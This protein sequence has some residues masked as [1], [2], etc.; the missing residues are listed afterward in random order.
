V[1]RILSAG[2]AQAVV[3][4]IV[5]AYTSATGNAVQADFSAV[6]AMK[7]RVLAG[8]PVDVVILTRALIDELA[9]SGHVAAGSRR[10]L[11]AVA[12]G[13]AVRAGTPLPDVSDVRKLRGNLLAATKVVCPD[14]ATAT[15][16]KAVMQMLDKLGIVAAVQ[17]RM[18]Y[19]P[20]GYA[21][22]KWLAESRGLL[23]MGIT[24]V[25]EILPN[26]GVRYVGPLP[27]ELRIATV[28]SA[29][30][31]SRAL[32]GVGAAD[33]IARLTANATR[34]LLAKAGYEFESR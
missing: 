2:A 18:Q 25:T 24:Q 28:Y 27:G 19:F 33:F 21:A 11:G 23:E 8:E 26:P 30:L 13:V 31:G 29:G 16:G 9:A 32:N 20:N 7:A 1:L 15:A 10:D 6:G 12:T 17:P 14:P 34:P 22:M 4:R 5:P 3:E